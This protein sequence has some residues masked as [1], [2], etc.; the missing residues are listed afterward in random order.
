[1]LKVVR[2]KANDNKRMH[3]PGCHRVHP[4]VALGSGFSC[5]RAWSPSLRSCHRRL[6]GQ[7]GGVQVRHAG[8]GWQTARSRRQCVAARDSVCDVTLAS[9][10][11]ALLGC[12]L[13]ARMH[14][15][16]VA[17]LRVCVRAA[18]GAGEARARGDQREPRA[19]GG[20][21][22]RAI[23]GAERGGAGDRGRGGGGGA[24]GAGRSRA[25]GEPL[26]LPNAHSRACV[27]E[28]GGR[29]CASHVRAQARSRWRW[30]ARQ[31]W[32]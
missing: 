18:A 24:S 1:M 22:A 21:G 30:G 20:G 3:S 11:L 32:R 15:R 4:R 9:F 19:R 13:R 5:E 6:V 25:P 27:R 7:L 10:C 12:A 14:A 31:R 28:R 8:K 26:A 29:A 16:A 17:R 23:H 2:A